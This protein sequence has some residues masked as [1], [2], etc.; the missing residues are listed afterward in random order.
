MTRHVFI[1][2]GGGTGG[3]LFPALAIAAALRERLGQR[4]ATLRSVFVCSDRACLMTSCMTV[5]W[6]IT[7][8]PIC[9]RF[10]SH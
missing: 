8:Q 3:H 6:S 7:I 4:G 9:W 2:A 5:V 10:R 1:F